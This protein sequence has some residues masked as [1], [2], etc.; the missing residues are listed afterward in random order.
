MYCI[1]VHDLNLLLQ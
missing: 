1:P